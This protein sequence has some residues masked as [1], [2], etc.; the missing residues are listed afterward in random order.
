MVEKVLKSSIAGEIRLKKAKIMLYRKIQERIDEYFSNGSNK[1][2]VIDGARQIGKSFIIRYMGQKHFR[3]YIELNLLEDSLNKRLFADI[4]NTEDF[5]LRLSMFAGD[6]MGDNQNT[7]VFLDEIQECPRLLTL[8][9]FLKQEDRF[10]Y[11]ASGSLLG[12][13]LSKTSSIPMGSIETVHMYPLDFEE[14]LLANG[15]NEFAIQGLKNRF[16]NKQ[17]LDGA[18]HEKVMDLFK[19]FL[20]VGGMPD[21]VNMFVQEKNIV[22]IRK[23]QDDIHNF[24]AADASKYDEKNRLKIRKIYDLIPSMME[25]KK[26]RIV[27]N[28]IESKKV[29]LDKYEDE[30]EYLTNAGVALEVSAITDVKFPL[31]QSTTKNLLKLY[32]NDVGILTGILYGNNINAVMNDIPSI[33]LGAVYETVVASELKAHGKKLYYYDNRLKG[34]V[35]FLIDDYDALTVVPIE[36][37]SGRDFTIHSALNNLQKTGSVQTG[38]VLSNSSEI[39]QKGNTLYLPVYYV[40]FL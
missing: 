26:K 12:V 25:N 7:L 17:S 34:E 21:A 18:M 13:A 29:K 39:M 31:V 2:L 8:L 35:D 14:F 5:Y 3:N 9:K 37:K 27:A 19:K 10:T 23:I 22:K 20:L 16:L 32:L 15:F 38:I 6:K 24:Y 30:F 1:V 40:M 4:Q 36:V 28:K 33:N 11:I